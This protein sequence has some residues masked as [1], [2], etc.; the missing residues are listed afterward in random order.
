MEHDPSAYDYGH[1]TFLVAK[2]RVV[3]QFGHIVRDWPEQ[4]FYTL[5]S[6]YRDRIDPQ[7]VVQLMKQYGVT[8]LLSIP[9]GPAEIIQEQY[10]E[11][12]KPQQP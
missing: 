6:T 3:K 7:H 12:Q 5:V 2:D 9:P 10:L 8:Q 4:T 1:F 11:Q